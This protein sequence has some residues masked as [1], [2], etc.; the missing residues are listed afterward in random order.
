MGHQPSWEPQVYG[1]IVSPSHPHHLLLTPKRKKIFGRIGYWIIAAAHDEKRHETR[2]TRHD[3]IQTRLRCPCLKS[4]FPFSSH[5]VGLSSSSSSMMDPRLLLLQNLV[6][7]NNNKRS[8]QSTICGC[9]R[10]A[11][12]GASILVLSITDCAPCRLVQTR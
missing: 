12:R 4:P 10:A 9:W 7:I 2:D 8:G 3:G 1:I 11:D 6:T 5:G